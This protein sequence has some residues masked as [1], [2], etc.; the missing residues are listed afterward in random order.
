[1]DLSEETLKFLTDGATTGERYARLFQVAI[2]FR[3]CGYSRAKAEWN[4]FFI[5][6][7]MQIP[8]LELNDVLYHAYYIKENKEAS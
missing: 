2:D 7:R 6:N 8:Y 1:M 5:C 4:L 3:K